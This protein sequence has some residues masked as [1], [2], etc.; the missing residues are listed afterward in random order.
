MSNHFPHAD[1]SF[2][3]GGGKMAELMRTY[4]WE[5]SPLGPPRNWS[6]SLRAAVS[7][8][9][10]AQAEIVLFWGPGVFETG[11]TFSAKDGPFY[12]ERHGVGEA[13]YLSPA[14]RRIPLSRTVISSR[15]M[16][17]LAK[18]FA[19]STL[20]NKIRGMLEA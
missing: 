20:G 1:L 4:D 19:M 6:P 12:I 15:A 13:V 14:I 2:L 9:L 11:Q 16:A 5:R 3:T 18:P 17:V 8:M 7:L 10:P